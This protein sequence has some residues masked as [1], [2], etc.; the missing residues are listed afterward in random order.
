MQQKKENI[1]SILKKV[2]EDVRPLKE[3][4]KE[5]NECKKEFLK[6]VNA[7]IKKH[8]IDANI[9]I[10]GSLAKKTIMRKDRYDIDIF[11]R[12]NKKYK[13]ENISD[14]TEKIIGCLK[15]IKH[16]NNIKRI[17]GSRDY[18]KIDI[19]KKF[20]LEIVPV[21]KVKN[22]RES[23]N[24]TDLSYSH[25]K[26]L[27]RKV[28]SEKI[29]DEIL[30]AKAFCYSTKCYGA[31]S[32]ING[33]SG[34]GLE[35]LICYYGNFLKFIKAI[36][37]NNNKEKIIIDIEKQFKNKQEILMNINSSKLK[38]PIILID[39]TFKQRNA[40]AALSEKTFEK[41][42]KECKKFI[43]N[44]NVNVFK[45]KKQDL[46][47]IK[48]N[49]IKKKYE[50]IL[51]EL[52][53]NKQDGDVSGSKLLKFYN[54]LTKEINKFF[55]IKNKG[56]DYPIKNKKNAEVFFVIK[57]KKEIIFNGP[58][59]KDKNNVLIFKKKHK[60]TFIKKN[61]IFAKEKIKFNIKKF[62]EKWKEKNKQRIKEMY[63]TELKIID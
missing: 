1:N 11:I 51:L 34:Y 15:K 30:L 18:F 60:N 35:L 41:F 43:K 61:K 47:K 25:V 49:S 36:T 31:E 6:E 12:F 38:S 52:Y 42:K 28:K 4:L 45:I 59:I 19:N 8:K 20:F 2:I 29:L 3:D 17:H 13:K 24:I 48:N 14:L 63:I 50:F 21:I 40:L 53:T 54:H 23:E 55:E 32:Y 46:N 33:F 26:Y 37:K 16:L 9:F 27:K 10:G 62:I 44:P 57:P 7:E 39:P 58:K 5:I 22:P 56:F